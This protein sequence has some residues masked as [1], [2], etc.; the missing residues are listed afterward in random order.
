MNLNFS[1]SF[2]LPVAS[3]SIF[4][5]VSV[6][7]LIPLMDRVIYPALLHCGINFTPL[8]RIGVGMLFAVAS[9]CVAG[10]VEI[11]RKRSGS[12]FTQTAFNVTT[13]ASSMSIFY[14]VPQFILIGTSEV[15]TSITGRFLKISQLIFMSAVAPYI[16]S[17]A[18]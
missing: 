13:N 4:D 6:L 15:F 2:N 12:F 8:R 9:V 10:V 7:S 3:L 11:E 14:Q 16:S 17:P 18:P 5:I 1:K